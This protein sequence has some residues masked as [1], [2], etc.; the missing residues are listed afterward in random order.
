VLPG[1]VGG[2]S[3][4]LGLF[5]LQMLPINYVGLALIL[6]G[7]GFFV[8]EA[9]V[10]SF[11]TLGLGGVAAF[12]FGALMLI[13]SD[14]PG[15]SIPKSLIAALTL[16]SAVFVIGVASMAARARRRPVVSGVAGLVGSTAVMIECSGSEGWAMVQGERWR[17][18]AQQD[19]QS[20]QQVRVSQ[21]NG[22]TLEVHPV[23]A[24]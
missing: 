22:L 5:G 6:L 8:A 17:V 16:S 13:D 14:V 15:L 19:L 3:L 18:H 12:A 9:F 7:I 21:V 1:V 10:P 24:T 20:G 2:I 11:G 23:T 4:L